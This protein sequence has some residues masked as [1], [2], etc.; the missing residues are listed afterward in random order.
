MNG[1]QHRRAMRICILGASLIAALIAAAPQ[2]SSNTVVEVVLVQPPA[3]ISSGA[4]AQFTVRLQGATAVDIERG[5]AWTA[6]KPLLFVDGWEAASYDDLG[7]TKLAR[8]LGDTA[9]FEFTAEAQ[10]RF[11]LE[12]AARRTAAGSESVQAA[13]LVL[14]VD[15][16]SPDVY[17]LPAPPSNVRI[18]TQ[19][20]ANPVQGTV[21]FYQARV[22][23]DS[24]LAIQVRG[25]GGN[26]RMTP[27]VTVSGPLGMT[28][29]ASGLATPWIDVASRWVQTPTTMATV[30]LEYYFNESRYQYTRSDVAIPLSFAAGPVLEVYP[31][32]TLLRCAQD[33]SMISCETSVANAGLKPAAL[34]P[35]PASLSVAVQTR[36][37]DARSGRWSGWTGT[38]RVDTVLN[39]PGIAVPLRVRA[40]AQ[41][42]SIVQVRAYIEGR[43]D[44]E[45]L[46]LADSRRS[47]A[48]V[49]WKASDPDRIR[50]P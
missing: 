19:A 21:A 46:V 47:V 31:P 44:T 9:V 18:E 24:D 13:P 25:Y 12:V 4:T 1:R 43:P 15:V 17:T 39:G 20:L 22:A 40:A 29:K 14:Y 49:R 11:R 41:P 28:V 33:R 42:W 2:A 6:A 45:V 23:A 27:E 26:W 5:V 16:T 32:A 34:P 8:N 7:R 10:G 50:R 36:V 35:T 30:S 48:D 37:R 3:A 38:S